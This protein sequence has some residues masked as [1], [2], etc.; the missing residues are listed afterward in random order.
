MT[1]RLFAG[2]SA[3]LLVLA[4][5]AGSAFA[6]EVKGPPNQINNTNTTGALEH[7]HSAC[8]ASGLNDFNQGQQVSQ[9]QTAADSWRYYGLPHGA[10]GKLGLCRGNAGGEE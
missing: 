8:A 5:G 7:A 3:A 2:L 4:L 10:P 1:R 6:G 9:V